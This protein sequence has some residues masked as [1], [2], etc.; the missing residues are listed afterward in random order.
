M[1]KKLA[2]YL[3]LMSGDEYNIPKQITSLVNFFY[4]VYFNKID[5]RERMWRELNPPSDIPMDPILALK[6]EWLN[7]E[8]HDFI[9][10]NQSY[11]AYAKSRNAW[12]FFNLLF[13]KS[14]LY[15]VFPVVENC[16]FKDL[17]KSFFKI[18]REQLN[19]DLGIPATL[20]V[21]GRYFI[22]HKAT[23]AHLVVDFDFCFQQPYTCDIKISASPKDQER[24]EEFFKNV[25]CALAEHDIY[26]KKILSYNKGFL[27]FQGIKPTLWN[28]LVLK[29]ETIEKIRVNSVCVLDNIDGLKR[30]GMCPN[31]NTLLISPPGMGKTTIF[32]AI[33]CEM[34]GNATLIWCTG[35]S[36]KYPEDVTSLFEAA[37]GLTPCAVIIEDMDLFG[38]DRGSLSNME[39]QVFNE[40]LAC[41]DGAQDNSG[42]I[43]L[44]STNDAKSMDSALLQ[45]PGRFHAKVEIPYPDLSDRLAI[46]RKFLHSYKCTPDDSVN[47]EVLNNIAQ[48][49]DGMTGDY[50]KELVSS[51]TLRAISDGR[52]TPHGVIF[53]A[54]DMIA[55]G[56]QV[57]DNYRIGKM[58]KMHHKYDSATE[59]PTEAA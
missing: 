38:R 31:R 17:I 32:R 22:T 26:H 54:S 25:I 3:P 46:M 16:R 23:G 56:E 24:A 34:V 40:F 19:I 13:G 50:L 5:E 42:L 12:A 20:P 6:E 58:S 55:A 15:E 7:A 43:V 44:A 4:D 51:I 30:V 37:R 39:S 2:T 14:A 49:M 18:E 29:P 21:F 11:P 45:R 28:D 35:K 52:S 33:S 27:D 1:F 10:I 8:V 48:M 47:K 53:N 36:I 41:L 57:L 9:C 59:G